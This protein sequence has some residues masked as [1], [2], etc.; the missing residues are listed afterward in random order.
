[1]HVVRVEQ[2][3]EHVDVKQRDLSQWC[4]LAGSLR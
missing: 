4:Y 3:D 1:M 2:G